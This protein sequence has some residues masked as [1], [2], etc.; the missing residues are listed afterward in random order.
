MLSVRLTLDEHDKIP[1]QFRKYS[2]SSGRVTFRVKDEFE[3]DLTIADEDFEK[4][5]WFIDFRFLFSPAPAELS[6][7]ARQFIE[8]KVND[9]L[10]TDGLAGCYKFLHEFVL[11]HQI[12]EFYRQALALSRNKWVGQ[13]KVERLHRAMSIQYWAGKSAAN[14][15]ERIPGSWIILGVISGQRPG[16][17]RDANAT[18]A[19]VLRWF[20]DGKEVQGSEIPLTV[21]K[22]SAE[23]LLK[24]VI[25][26]HVEHILSSINAKLKTKPRFATRQ[27]NLRLD[28]S[29]DEPTDSALT[30]QLV[31][32][33]DVVVRIAAITG[34]FDLSP[35]TTVMGGG[36]R[37]FDASLN[38]AEDGATILEQLR[39]VYLTQELNRRAKS[40]GWALSMPPIKPDE[41]KQ[42]V[43]TSPQERY[44]PVWLRRPA[45]NANWYVLVSLSLE[46]D[47]WWLVEV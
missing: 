6:E 9:A 10:A 2:I 18:S 5:F 32:K 36:V 4:Q 7:R 15:R 38:P 30:M 45:W 12:S 21:D 19:L 16:E 13:L 22:I 23:T 37:K 1:L 46:G 43:S 25:A 47:R 42:H 20:R 35:Q 44:Q 33:D 8:A 29:K 24:A 31:D 41:L 26:R 11:T 40:T 28:L 34:F 39:S 3:V 17:P 27:A 14:P